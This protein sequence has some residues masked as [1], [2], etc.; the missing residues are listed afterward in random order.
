[1][2]FL[3]IIQSPVIDRDDINQEAELLKLEGVINPSKSLIAK[4]LAN[5]QPASLFQG[6]IG[7]IARPLE[8]SPGVNIIALERLVQWSIVQSERIQQAVTAYLDD[9]NDEVFGRTIKILQEEGIIKIE[10]KPPANAFSFSAAL[11]R[12]LE[13][14]PKGLEIHDLYTWARGIH[15]AKRPEA[16][17]R[18]T[19]RRLVGNNT[20][21]LTE[22]KRYKIH[23]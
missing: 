13:R 14:E 23:S 15:S 16:T 19:L 3:Y 5:Q 4:R 8:V 7:S 2:D 9:P 20:L 17:V 18:Q 21:M 10:P 12:L 11:I 22:D 1:M 6:E